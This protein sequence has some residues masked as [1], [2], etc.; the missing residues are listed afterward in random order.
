MNFCLENICDLIALVWHGSL[1]FLYPLELSCPPFTIKSWDELEC[2][3]RM[4]DFSRKGLLWLDAY[5]P[6]MPSS[7]STVSAEGLGRCTGARISSDA[8]LATTSLNLLATLH[9]SCPKRKSLRR[10]ELAAEMVALGRRLTDVALKRPGTLSRC[11][12][13]AA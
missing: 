13:S 8:F 11:A 10:Q 6:F 1:R 2:F 9:N 12:H 5:T 3:N 7:H 4:T